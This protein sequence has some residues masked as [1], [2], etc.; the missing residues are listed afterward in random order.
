M[1][2]LLAGFLTVTFIFGYFEA[3]LLE[4]GAG[5]QAQAG[6]GTQA[7]R[8]TLSA[9][10]LE[11]SRQVISQETF[12]RIVQEMKSEGIKAES[13]KLGPAMRHVWVRL[14]VLK[15]SGKEPAL[16]SLPERAS[17][18]AIYPVCSQTGTPLFMIETQQKKGVWQITGYGSAETAK[19]YFGCRETHQKN[20]K[21]P[22]ENYVVLAVPA[23]Q[24]EFLAYAEKD[25]TQEWL[26]PLM[27]NAEV[28][29]KYGLNFRHGEAVHAEDALRQL[30]TAAAKY[31]ERKIED[32][33]EGG[34]RCNDKN[35][36]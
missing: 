20:S 27:P 13:V 11:E 17:T 28:N 30:L 24:Y 15:K 14:D 32:G 1:R 10:D 9:L 18:K 34:E 19:L 12:D 5:A 2:I 4:S 25:G 29:V 26:M 7:K 31:Q 6:A 22:V 16:W 36:Q 3:R 23:L 35:K 33:K 8:M 21:R